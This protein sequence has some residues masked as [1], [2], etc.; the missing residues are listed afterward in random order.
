MTI[1]PIA[2]ALAAAAA[3]ATHTAASR[4]ILRRHR[5]KEA[6]WD[7]KSLAA[8]KEL[9]SPGA[10]PAGGADAGRAEAAGTWLRCK[11]AMARAGTLDPDLAAEIRDAGLELPEK[12]PSSRAVPPRWDV[13]P[14]IP[15][16]AAAALAAGALA[17]AAASAH[18]A[19]AAALAAAIGATCAAAA[20][21]DSAARVIPFWLAALA[22]AEGFALQTAASGLPAAAG[23]LAAGAALS[24][25]VAIAG[26][27]LE[28]ATGQRNI[29]GGDLAFIP[30]VAACSGPGGAIGALAALSAAALALA[31]AAAVGKVGL[32]ERVPYGPA[33]ALAA[34]VGSMCSL[35]PI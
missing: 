27:A 28:R 30:A 2:A 8:A 17:L 5:R 31:G 12:D 1:A 18:G 33:L 26:S 9:C 11:Q 29:G 23:S 34:V 13:P 16:S 25:A 6:R 3:A 14:S 19:L 21:A 15:W 20:R 32:K 10:P 22:A 35:A 7:A 24:A 4:A